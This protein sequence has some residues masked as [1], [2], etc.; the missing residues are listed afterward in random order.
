MKTACVLLREGIHYCAQKFDLHRPY[1]CL[2]SH[3][4]VSNIIILY[5]RRL[6]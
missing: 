5:S 3:V 2:L 4:I 6:S 1:I